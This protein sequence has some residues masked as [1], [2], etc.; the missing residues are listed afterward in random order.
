MYSWRAS[1]GKCCGEGSPQAHH[2]TGGRFVASDTALRPGRRCAAALLSLSARPRVSS[3]TRRRSL[4][5]PARNMI[6]DPYLS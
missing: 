6:V 2:E 3:H 1:I 5:L 4:G